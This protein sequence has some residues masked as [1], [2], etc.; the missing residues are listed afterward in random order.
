[1]GTARVP[2]RR[3]YVQGPLA[4]SPRPP[5]P[6]LAP[7]HT[8]VQGGGAERPHPGAGPGPAPN[9][10]PPRRRPPLR[11]SAHESWGSGASQPRSVAGLSVP[12]SL[13][14]LVAPRLLVAR[15]PSQLR[16]LVYRGGLKAKLGVGGGTAHTMEPRRP[17]RGFPN[18][19]RP[20]PGLPTGQ[21]ACLAWPHSSSCWLGQCPPPGL[22]VPALPERRSWEVSRARDSS[23]SAALLLRQLWE[24]PL[25]PSSHSLACAHGSELLSLSQAHKR[26]LIVSCNSFTH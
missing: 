6:V 15:R 13:S 7:R 8:E 9:Q 14:R 17:Q 10:D 25:P 11:S 19:L 2:A 12:R 21:L 18:Y 5:P 23:Q 26:N 20:R 4:G 1:M 24:L 22:P 3:V 16:E